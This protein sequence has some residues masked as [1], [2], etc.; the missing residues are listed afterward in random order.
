MLIIEDVI[1]AG[2]AVRESIP[3]LKKAADVQ[4][5]GLIIA[6]DRMEKGQGDSS[7]VRELLE[8]YGI[9]TFSIVNIRETLETLLNGG[10]GFEEDTMPDITSRMKEYMKKYCVS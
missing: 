8:D 7:A 2:T 4:I 10:P 3:L 1:T 6:V 9:P 5:C